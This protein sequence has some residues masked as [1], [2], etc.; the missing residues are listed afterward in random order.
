[1]STAVDLLD[2][3]RRHYLPDN[4]PPGGLFAAE[5][6]SPDGR[7]R[8]DALWM[9]STWAGA[10]ELI[11]HELKVTR[12]DVVAEL[13]DPTKADAWARYCNRWWL[14]VLSP[15]LVD[16]LDVPEHWGIMAPPS[17]RR[18]RSMTIVRE[19]PK[20]KPVEQA[21]GFR[22]VAVWMLHRH[23]EQLAAAQSRLRHAEQ[24]LARE[25][26]HISEI[27]AGAAA[28]VDPRTQRIGAILRELDNR[29]GFD[30][31]MSDPDLD[32]LIVDA[33]RDYRKVRG[34]ADTARFELAELV[35]GAQK[36]AEPMKRTADA[37]SK[38]PTPEVM[39][40]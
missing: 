2:V 12:S 4:R 7:R 22:R 38:L 3:L 35:R 32:A 14:V 30:D 24:D 27:R 28:R 33:V 40:R 25:R 6:E 18:T 8:A 5:I 19:A 29:R 1:M 23:A 21:P 31:W 39:S 20:L 9:P 34:L 17:G 26:Q 13:N 36:F 16:G 15:A 37:L 11:G 10:K